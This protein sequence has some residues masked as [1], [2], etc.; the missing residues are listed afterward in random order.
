M[1]NNRGWL[2]AKNSRM[3][4]GLETGSKMGCDPPE[5]PDGGWWM[6]PT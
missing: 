4:Q 2:E 3:R 6:V 5:G 1:G